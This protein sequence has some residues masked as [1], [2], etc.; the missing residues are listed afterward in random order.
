MS[1]TLSNQQYAENSVIAWRKRSLEA[2]VQRLIA[3]GIVGNKM[4]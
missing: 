3:A 2:T 4:R 1:K